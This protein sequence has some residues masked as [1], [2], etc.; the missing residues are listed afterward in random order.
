VDTGLCYANGITL[1]PDQTLLCVAGYRT[2]WVY[3]YQM[4][5]DRTLTFKQLYYWIHAPDNKDDMVTDGLW[6]DHD[7][8]R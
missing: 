1:S 2:H 5:T 6:M 7:R 3:S 8:R 4:Q